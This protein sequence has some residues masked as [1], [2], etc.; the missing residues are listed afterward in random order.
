MKRVLI[1]HKMGFAELSRPWDELLNAARTRNI[2]LTWEWLYSWW[3]TYGSG[4]AALHV[5]AWYDDDRLVAILPAWIEQRRRWAAGPVTRHLRFLGT[6]EVY[7]D[8]LDLIVL[9]SHEAAVLADLADYLANANAWDVAE[10]T[11]M[12]ANAAILQLDGRSGLRTFARAEGGV[13]PVTTL[14]GDW[15]SFLASLSRKMRHEVR[16]DLKKLRGSGEIEHRIAGRDLPLAEAMDEFV[17][18]HQDRFVQRGEPGNFSSP[19]FTAFHQAAAA[20]LLARGWLNLEFLAVNGANVACRYQFRY[21]DAVYDYLP[22]FDTRWSRQSVGVVLLGM[23][24]KAAIDA[25]LRRFEFLRGREDYKYR[26]RAVDQ[27]LHA[28]RIAR[29]SLRPTLVFQ[30]LRFELLARAWLKRQLGR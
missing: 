22:G 19:R 27:E 5:L 15:D 18:L 3:E 12:S 30:A 26:W 6:G 17:R 13:C 7:S 24:V 28:L 21:D 20:R 23:S 1:E 8:F 14:E 2:F 4:T 29:R 25:G 11:D 10:F 16:S 9:G